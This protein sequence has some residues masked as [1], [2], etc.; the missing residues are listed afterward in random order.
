M[1]DKR[2]DGKPID[3][4]RVADKRMDEKRSEATEAPRPVKLLEPET[5]TAVMDHGS[6]T[7]FEHRWDTVQAHFVD[8]PRRAVGEAGNLMADFMEHAAKNLRQRRTELDSART[9][10]MDT[11]AMRLELRRYKELMHKIVGDGNGA[12]EP[13]RIEPATRPAGPSRP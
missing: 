7:D 1:E 9:G 3:D 6:I 4:V 11:E 2:M 5:A 12:T 10:E 8:D 13:P